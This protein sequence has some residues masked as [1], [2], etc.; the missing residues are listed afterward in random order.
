MSVILNRYPG[1]E[2]YTT[3]LKYY[4]IIIILLILYCTVLYP[5]TCTVRINYYGIACRDL[6]L[7]PVVRVCL[8]V[9]VR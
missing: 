5:C 2:H 9:C 3:V 6:L 8:C 4:L 7:M 1:T